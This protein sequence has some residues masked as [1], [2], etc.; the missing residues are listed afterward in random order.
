MD[1][2]ELGKFETIRGF[3]FLHIYCCGAPQEE[4]DKES[5][6]NRKFNNSYMIEILSGQ[7]RTQSINIA[8]STYGW[9]INTKTKK[10]YCPSCIKKG[11]K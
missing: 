11:Y 2:K 6:D 3:Y 1:S 8:R 5:I 10:A 9:K 7:S 4:H